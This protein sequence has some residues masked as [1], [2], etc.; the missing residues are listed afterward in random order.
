[1]RRSASARSPTQPVKYVWSAESAKAAT[2]AATNAMTTT[3]SVCEIAVGDPVVDGDLPEVWREKCDERERDER[4]DGER[5][6]TRIRSREAEEDPEPPPRLS[7]RPV[8][9]ARGAVLREMAARLPDP[10]SAAFQWG[11][12]AHH[13]LRA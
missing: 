3:T 7:P 4:D 10:Q 12:P 2:A 8:V 13:P 9:D 1:M 6:S 11:T 5:R